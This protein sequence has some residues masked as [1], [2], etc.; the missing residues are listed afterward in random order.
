MSIQSES[1]VRY[2]N[3]ENCGLF[4]LR[5]R[6]YSLPAVGVMLTVLLCVSGGGGPLVGLLSVRSLSQRIHSHSGQRADG[7]E[8]CFPNKDPANVQTQV[9]CWW[10]CRFAD[11]S[12]RSCFV[13]SCECVD[14]VCVCELCEFSRC[15]VFWSRW[16]LVFLKR[17]SNAANLL[18]SLIQFFSK[19]RKWADMSNLSQNFRLRLKQ[20]ERNFEVSMV[21]F[22]KFE[23]IFVGMFQNPQGEEP[24][25]KSRTRKH[26]QGHACAHTRMRAPRVHCHTYTDVIL[27]LW[28]ICNLVC[29]CFSCLM[30][31]PGR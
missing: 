31:L 7:R 17:S 14:Q 13:R 10:L 22:R 3:R 23:H 16:C 5:G 24:P 6:Y 1:D 15:W 12:R 20:L 11:T 25:R 30:D 27:H 29:R 8:L 19:M 18:H 21:I 26:R 28:G 9:R 2:H 4:L